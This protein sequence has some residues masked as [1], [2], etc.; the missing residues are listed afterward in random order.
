MADKEHTQKQFLKHAEMIKGYIFA[1]LPDVNDTE[2]IF[3]EVFIVVTQKSDT[4]REGTNF[5]AWVRSIARNKVLQHFDKQKKNKGVVLTEDSIESISQ[6][7]ETFEQNW[8][9]HRNALEQC[10]EK[11]APKGREL[12]RLRYL[13][14]MP[15]RRIARKLNRTINGVSSALSKVRDF[16]RD[17]VGSAFEKTGDVI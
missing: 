9:I 13:E 11:I 12:L 14:D 4:Y 10:M 3:Q 16:L 15:P 8:D 6:E 2:D 7:A 1:F 5:M 17:C